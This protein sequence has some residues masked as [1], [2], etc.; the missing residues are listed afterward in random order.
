M[1]L[2]IC[3]GFL[4]P[5]WRSNPPLHSSPVMGLDQKIPV[6]VTIIKEED[7]ARK[8]EMHPEDKELD[9]EVSLWEEAFGRVED[10]EDSDFY[11][12]EAEDGVEGQKEE[13]KGNDDD[14]D[15]V[16]VAKDDSP[17]IVSKED[18]QEKDTIAKKND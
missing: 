18:A 17:V 9:N 5:M 10:A 13:Q 6:K 4:R 16:L 14:N 12:D 15:D 2:F 7:V 3:S 11:D 8:Y 1:K